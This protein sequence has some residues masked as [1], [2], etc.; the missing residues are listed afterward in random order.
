MFAAALLAAAISAGMIAL[1]PVSAQADQKVLEAC[2][3]DRKTVDASKLPE[4][5]DPAKCPVEDVVIKDGAAASALP[6]PG[7]SVYVEALTLSGAE[8]LTVTRSKDGTVELGEVG[9]ESL[10]VEPTS[11]EVSALATNDGCSDSAYAKTGWRVGGKLAYSFNRGTTPRGVGGRLAAERAVRSAAGNIANTRNRCRLGDR[12]SARS[13]YMGNTRAKAQINRYG[14]CE[15][16]DGKSVVSFGALSHPG[17]LATTCTWYW[18]QTGYSK[19]ASSDI[20]LNTH[21]KRWTTNPGAGSCQNRFDI[22][23]TA[24]HEFGHTFGL[25]HPS[26]SHPSLT[27]NAS[28]AGPCQASERSLGR[29]DVI[30]LGRIY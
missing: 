27:M 19:V 26:G 13:T 8:E 20:K 12:V 5:W 6:A 30:G 22:E 25:S 3:T 1:S 17:A 15:G 11:S 2:K 29:G 28:S 10:A 7:Q 9:S 24:T 21:Q 14:V 23:S 18:P 16:N 4:V